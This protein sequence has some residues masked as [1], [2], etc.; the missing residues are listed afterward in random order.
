MDQAVISFRA[1]AVDDIPLIQSL[2]RT[3]WEQTYPAIISREQIEIMLG[4]MYDTATIRDEL[5]KGVAWEIV[6]ENR[7]PIGYLSCSMTGPHECKLHKLYILESHHS[8]GIGR[9]CLREAAEYARARRAGTLILLVNRDNEKAIRAYRAFG[10]TVTESF[11]W[12]YKPGA[13]LHDYK[14]TLKL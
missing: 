6:E 9:R 11:D 8:R 5:E 7:L 13:I 10:F 3:I 1:A 14:M 2:S 4:H 12:E